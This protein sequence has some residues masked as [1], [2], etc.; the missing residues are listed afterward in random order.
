V[1]L[2]PAVSEHNQVNGMLSLYK[3]GP[4]IYRAGAAIASG[5][6]SCLRNCVTRNSKAEV[7]EIRVRRSYLQ[8]PQA[9]GRVFEMS[10][11]KKSSYATTGASKNY[12]NDPR[13][14]PED[15]W[16]P[17]YLFRYRQLANAIDRNVNP[18]R[19]CL[20]NSR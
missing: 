3:V 13:T 8:L 16:S 18:S 14:T 11:R 2:I 9:S 20:S 1:K 12:T 19:N 4:K 5:R 6:S 15:N 10:R 7:P 17:R